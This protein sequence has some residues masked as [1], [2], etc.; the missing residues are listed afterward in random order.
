MRKRIILYNDHSSPLDHLLLEEKNWFFFF[1][2]NANRIVFPIITSDLETSAIANVMSPL[3]T[4]KMKLLTTKS[5]SKFSLMHNTSQF[6][7]R[8][9]THFVSLVLQFANIP[10]MNL[11]TLPSH[12]GHF[13]TLLES[14]SD[15]VQ[16]R[17]VI[18]LFGCFQLF[19]QNWW[20]RFPKALSLVIT[21][22]HPGF[23]TNCLSPLMGVTRHFY[24]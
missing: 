11:W 9:R 24:H 20:T 10:T 16:K 17:P 4:W 21:S 23:R 15:M 8:G 12:W 22:H 2:Q 7:R 6:P 13:Q 18:D 5:F 3:G 14:P 19:H 1:Y